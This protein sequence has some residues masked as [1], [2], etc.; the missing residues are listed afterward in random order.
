MRGDRGRP[1]PGSVRG[2]RDRGVRNPRA[3]TSARGRVRPVR[4]EKARRGRL[5]GVKTPGRRLRALPPALTR[6]CVLATA[7][8]GQGARALPRRLLR[9]GRERRGRVSPVLRPSS[10]ALRPPPGPSK[11]PAAPASGLLAPPPA[12]SPPQRPPDPLSSLLPVN[13]F[14]GRC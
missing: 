1:G 6:A 12:R 2:G 5:R 4:R 7:E 3:V 14:L 8:G 10:P 11:L 9:A 13:A